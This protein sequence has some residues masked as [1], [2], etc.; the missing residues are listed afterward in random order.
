[1]PLMGPAGTPKGIRGPPDMNSRPGV[2]KCHSSTTQMTPKWYQ[3]GTEAPQTY[4][5]T[6]KMAAEQLLFVCSLGALEFDEF[7][8]PKV[9]TKLAQ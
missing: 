6:H 7:R 2:Q 4:Y 3:D 5:R 8:P 9:R 1:M